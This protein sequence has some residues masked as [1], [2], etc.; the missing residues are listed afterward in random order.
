V[1]RGWMVTFSMTSPFLE[2]FYG[3][4]HGQF[5]MFRASQR[6][7]RTLLPFWQTVHLAASAARPT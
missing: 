4:Y 7:R 5:F 6:G 1:G 2:E 3:L